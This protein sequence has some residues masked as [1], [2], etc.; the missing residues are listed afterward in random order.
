MDNPLSASPA[1]PSPLPQLDVEGAVLDRYGHG[2]L[3]TEAALCSPVDYDARYLEALP[4]EILERDYGCGDPT[5]FVRPGETV[6]DLGSGGG[7]ICYIMAQIVGPSGRVIGVDFNDTM[8]ALSR[9]YLDE[10]GLRLGFSNVEFRKGKIQDLALDC[11]KLDEYLAA[12]PIRHSADLMRVRR[13]EEELRTRSPLIP[14]QSVDLIVSNCVLNLVRPDDRSL[15]FRELNRVL[16]M[17]G[18]V[19][20]SDIVSDE[21]VPEPLKQDAELWSGCVSG[22]FQEEEFLHA[23][24]SAGFHGMTL[25]SW[26]AKPYRTVEGIEF[27]SITLTAHKGKEGPCLERHQAV[28]YR[29]P[30][31]SVTDDDHHTYPRGVRV[32]VCEKTF[33]LLQNGPYRKDL[34]FIEPRAVDSALETLPFD[35]SRIA[36]RHPRESKGLDYRATTPAE[37]N[38]CEPSSGCC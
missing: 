4:D 12:Q 20:I 33:R 7:K 15:L 32:A 3:A 19:A 16:K 29:G 31:R 38:C 6:L 11:E 25:E 35:C 1:A 8:L 10:M 37:G 21:P 22:A 9:K 24:E 26:S 34:I 14:D 36:P 27:R 5:R 18:R 2:A 28:I 13:F 17:G 30:Y 23:F